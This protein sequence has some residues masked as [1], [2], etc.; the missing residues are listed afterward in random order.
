MLNN[1]IAHG[2]LDG[3]I[4]LDVMERSKFTEGTKPKSFK[5]VEDVE[6]TPTFNYGFLMFPPLS[7]YPIITEDY[8][9][10]KT[11]TSGEV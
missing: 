9:R 11:V 10:A 5:P 2:V 1:R 4:R 3:G 6:H 7:Q 8:I